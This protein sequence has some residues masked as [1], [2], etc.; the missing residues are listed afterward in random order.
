MSDKQVVKGITSNKTKTKIT[1]IFLLVVGIYLYTSWSTRSSLIDL[2]DGRNGFIRIAGDLFPPNWSYASTVWVKLVETLHMAIIATTIAA[3]ISIPISLLSA[4]NLFQSPFIHQP[5]RFIMNVLRTIPD[6]LLAVIFVGIFG[7]GVFPGIMALIIFSL[8]LLAKLMYET[9]ESID[10]N[11]VEAIRASGGN[12]LQ[13][14]SYAVIPQVLPQFVSFSLYVF[15]VN[16]R[17][18]LVLGFVG[19]GGIG[20]LLQQQVGFFNYPRIM[21]III[22]IFAAVVVIDYISNK[23]R[24]RLI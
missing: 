2:W 9:I 7:V 8:G 6:I 17:A 22:I 1:I 19:A 21:T 5:V 13:V 3:I 18:S 11:P 4:A 20:L 16:V 24:E 14:I 23:I 10:M 15:E 12:T